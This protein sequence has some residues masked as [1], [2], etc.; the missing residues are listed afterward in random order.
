MSIED[1]DFLKKNSIKE[2]YLFIVDSKNRDY[3]RFP[4]P[5]SY[6]VSFDVPLR[7]VIG[8][9]VMDASI[10]RTMYSVDKYNNTFYCYIAN[11]NND[12]LV[13]NGL[14][15][16][17]TNMNIFTKIDFVPGNYTIQTFLLNF[18]ILMNTKSNEDPINFSSPIQIISYSNPPELTNKITFTCKKP[19]ILNMYDSTLAETLGFSLNIKKEYNEILYKYISKYEGNSKFLRLYHSYYNSKTGNYEITSPGIFFFIGEKYIILRSPEIEEHAYGSIA[20]TNYNL[21]I[22]KF[23]VNTLG[24]NDERLEITK[25]PIREFH[26]IGKLSK[27]TFRFETSNGNLYDFKGINHIITYVITY[28]RPLLSNT[29]EFKPI[30]NPNYLNNFN[31]YKYINEEQELS[32]EEDKNEFSRDKLFDIYKRNELL[33]K[34]KEEEEDD[35]DEEYEEEHV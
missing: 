28:Y 34:N 10:P 22:V 21:G 11:D 18:N 5:N 9:N 32:D 25:L 14:D 26:P 2:N 27:L 13:S 17:N 19:F 23:K 15:P 1:I 6:E 20:Y 30:L 24:F 16:N 8:I 31:E 33:Y 29:N 12:T 35:D 7:N 3:L 4:D